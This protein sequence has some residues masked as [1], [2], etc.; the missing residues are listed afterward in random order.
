MRNSFGVTAIVLL[1][2][3][4]PARQSLIAQ[5]GED[6]Q[7]VQDAIA[8]AEGGSFTHAECTILN[9][10]FVV[11]Y[12][13]PILHATVSG[14]VVNASR[15]FNIPT[16]FRSPTSKTSA[17]P[18][19]IQLE[20]KAEAIAWVISIYEQIVAGVS[21]SA[22]APSTNASFNSALRTF[23]SVVMP[24]VN[25][26]AL[27]EEQA[28]QPPE[29]QAGGG[30]E[31]QRQ[32][33]GRGKPGE[34]SA[35]VEY[36]TFAFVGTDGK[37]IAF[38]GA[39][40]RTTDS[41]GLGFG[42][43]VAYSRV[44]FDKNDN[45]LQSGEAMAF[46]KIPLASFL[47]I[48]GNVTGTVSRFKTFSQVNPDGIDQNV[49]SVGYGPFVSLR[50]GFESGHML[51]GGLMYQIIDPHEEL[52]PDKENIRVL[53][54][55]ALAVFSVSEKLALSAEVF[56]MSNL[57]LDG[58]DDSFGVV[59]PQ[60]HFYISESFGLILGYKTVLGIDDYDSSEFTLGS[61][62]RF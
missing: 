48:G 39:F 49:N 19:S 50:A 55:G 54:Y 61:S 28:V 33:R 43:R 6:L 36:E 32:G 11:D 29:Q 51:A 7:C 40:E 42:L 24:N 25:P 38:R 3:A 4:I 13:D 14:P 62:V 8:A 27:R 18:A 9:H 47:E 46:I 2:L 57:D 44:S 10:L 31:E 30:E 58:G 34:I 17:G 16:T 52:D 37:T 15:S 53:A 26:Q 23:G 60:I 5:E 59:H 1:L 35:D 20:G 21:L 56:Q 22:F 41:G 12:N 45:K